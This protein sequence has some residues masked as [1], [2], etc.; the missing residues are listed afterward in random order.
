MPSIPS[1][2]TPFDHAVQNAP[3]P[4]RFTFPFYYEPHPLCVLA[5]T[6]LQQHLSQQNEWQHNFGLTDDTNNVIGKMFGVMLVQNEQGE[7]GYLAAYSGKL[8]NSNHLAGFVPPVFDMLHQDDFFLAENRIINDINQKITHQEDNPERHRLAALKLELTQAST[9]ALDDQREVMIQGRKHRKALRATLASSPPSPQDQAAEHALNQQSVTEKN[10]LR[11]LKLSWDSRIGEVG[12]QFDKLNNALLALK[13]ERKQRSNA[14]QQALF[15]QYTFLNAKG[16]HKSLSDIFAATVDRTPPAGAGEC[17]APKLLHYAYLHSLRPLAMAEFWWGTPPKS[18][19]RR[20]R[21]FYPACIR[22]CQPILSHMLEGLAVDPNPLLVN[23]AVGKSL[24]IIYQ[25]DVMLIVNKPAE[26]LSVPGKH[27]SDSVYQRIVQDF[28]QATGPIIVHRL[29]MST[30]GL[31]VIALDKQTHE[32][33]QKQFIRRTV[34]KCYVALLD[35]EIIGPAIEKGR[36]E[37]QGIITLPLRGDLDDRPRQLVCHEH[38]KNAQTRWEIIDTDIRHI[39]SQSDNTKDDLNRYTKVYLYPKTGRTHQL[40]VHCAH[41]QGLNTPILGD[42]LYGTRRDR[43][44]LHAQSLTLTH[45]V[46]GKS[47]TFQADETF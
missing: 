32:R 19:V 11:D 23:P 44:Y 31:M 42:D 22:K 20:H 18:Q 43:L 12:A 4:E 45:P 38:G 29:D 39:K 37:A 6:Q 46:T 17:A 7:L 40:R 34:T 30:S 21:Q 33:L 13:L 8:A 2:F 5:A 24:P 25:D 35:G 41:A 9:A 16:E 14:L 15:D 28:P 3:L 27:I 1:C 10:Q 47:M 36:V 26:F